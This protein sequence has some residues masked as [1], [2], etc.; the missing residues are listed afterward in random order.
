M[1][2]SSDIL[3][4]IISKRLEDVKEAKAKVSLE[5]LKQQLHHLQ[6]KDDPLV[7]VRIIV[8]SGLIVIQSVDFHR[9]IRQAGKMALMAEIKRASPSKGNIAPADFSLSA[10]VASYTNAGMDAMYALFVLCALQEWR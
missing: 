6:S 9:R 2:S 3:S 1:A 10:Q 5:Q 4:K 8:F 7:K